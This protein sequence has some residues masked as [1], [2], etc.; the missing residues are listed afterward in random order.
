[1]D[2]ICRICNGDE[3]ACIG[4]TDPNIRMPINTNFIDPKLYGDVLLWVCFGCGTVQLNVH[5]IDS[6]RAVVEKNTIY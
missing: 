5:T 2:E 6:V 4:K 3:W 1:M